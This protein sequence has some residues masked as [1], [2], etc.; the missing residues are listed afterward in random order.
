VF[1]A[2]TIAAFEIVWDKIYKEHINEHYDLLTYLAKTWVDLYKKKFVKCFTNKQ[3]HFMNVTTSKVESS[4]AA[5]KK[6]LQ[7]STG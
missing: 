3:L 4:Y 5:L 7:F 2:P 6:E 1:Y